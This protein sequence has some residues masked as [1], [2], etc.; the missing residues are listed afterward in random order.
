MLSCSWFNDEF[1]HS[2]ADWS[3]YNSAKT[4]SA[5]ETAALICPRGLVIAMG[6][7]DNLF[8]SKISERE[9][10]RV[11]SFYENFGCPNNYDF[12]VFDGTHEF[13]KNNRGI[14]FLFNFLLSER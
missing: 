7:N 2:W 13:D 9:S 10:E 3:Y 14:D 12:Y 8:D 6:N 11:K 1:L 4:F 5:A